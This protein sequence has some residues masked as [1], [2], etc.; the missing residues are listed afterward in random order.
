M[1]KIFALTIAM[2]SVFSAFNAH[3]QEDSNNSDTEA[4][5]VVTDGS[6]WSEKKNRVSVSY[7]YASLP[8]FIDDF[9]SGMFHDHEKYTCYGTLN[10]SYQHSINQ[11]FSIGLD[12]SF[13]QGKINNEYR[14]YKKSMKYFSLMPSFR[15]YWFHATKVSMYSKFAFGACIYSMKMTERSTE[16]ESYNEPDKDE[17]WYAGQVSPVGIELGGQS[18]RAFG[19]V[20]IGFEGLQL[21]V[22]YS[23]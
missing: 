23:F 6:Q 10:A 2:V 19:E 21:G 4:V 18:L 20:G 7:G 1:K 13:E 14:G 9:A 22:R 16:Y 11:R 17:F 5:A 15:V 3:A 12:A 8:Q